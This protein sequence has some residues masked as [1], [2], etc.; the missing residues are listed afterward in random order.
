MSQTPG[1]I[2]VSFGKEATPGPSVAEDVTRLESCVVFGDRNQAVFGRYAFYP[3]LIDKDEFYLRVDD[4]ATGHVCRVESSKGT[5]IAE[6]VQGVRL[7]ILRSIVKALRDNPGWGVT[8]DSLVQSAQ[9]G[10]SPHPHP[11][12]V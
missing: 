7:N 11:K 6:D 12:M 4:R 8:V 1:P 9:Q 3:H 5:G 2:L 10:Q